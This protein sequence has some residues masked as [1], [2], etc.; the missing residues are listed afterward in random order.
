MDRSGGE[1]AAEPHIE[2]LPSTR[3][4][5]VI[6]RGQVEAQYPEDRPQKALRLAEG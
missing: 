3:E 5:R 1:D 6:R 4:R 2:P